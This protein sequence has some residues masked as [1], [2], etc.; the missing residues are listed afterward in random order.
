MLNNR[1]AD[2]WT[3]IDGCAGFAGG[4]FDATLRTQPMTASGMDSRPSPVRTPT[5]RL[6][7]FRPFIRPTTLRKFP[8]VF[9]IRR[10]VS[11]NGRTAEV[12]PTACPV[13]LRA[14]C[15]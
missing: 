4:A 3:P 15:G 11:S 12:E 5:V 9:R 14:L 6:R 7:R 2:P 1:D 10:R 8:E 13:G